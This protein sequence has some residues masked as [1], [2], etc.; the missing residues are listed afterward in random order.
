MQGGWRGRGRDYDYDAAQSMPDTRL[1]TCFAGKV[2]DQPPFF[3]TFES[4]AALL[5]K[6]LVV[7]PKKTSQGCF[8]GL[9][10]THIQ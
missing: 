1:N 7:I 3:N 4:F 9:Y 10:D 8:A 2:V 5:V 6:P